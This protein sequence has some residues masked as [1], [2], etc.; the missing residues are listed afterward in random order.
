M[1]RSTFAAA[2]DRKLVSP[3]KALFSQT[4]VNVCSLIDI[5]RTADVRELLFD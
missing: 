4:R 3:K 2:P 1:A 5:L